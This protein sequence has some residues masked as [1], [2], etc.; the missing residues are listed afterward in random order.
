MLAWLTAPPT[1]LGDLSR[2]EA[3]R[4]QLTVSSTGAFSNDDLPY[5]PPPV[6]VEAPPAEVPQAPVPLA[7]P[8]PPPA[9]EPEKAP[10]EQGEEWWR[11]RMTTAR[12]ALERDEVLA[13]ALQTRVNSLQTDVVNRDDPAQRAQ[14]QMQLQRAL[15][16][17][18]RLTRQIE[19]D[20]KT[21]DALQVEAR[22][23]GIPPGWIR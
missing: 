17:V 21:I 10:E 9:A 15:N 12:A 20:Q 14:L 5:M 16:E 3:L 4:R 7:T 23:K 8:P 13:D 2:R 6:M 22:K 18:A 1:S 19:V 11:D